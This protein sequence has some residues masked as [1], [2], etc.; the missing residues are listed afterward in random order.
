M[1]P[2]IPAHAA[3]PGER[4]RSIVDVHTILIRD[5]GRILLLERGPGRYGAGLLHLPSGHLE[6]GEPLHLGAARETVEETGVVIDPADLEIAALVHHRQDPSHTRVGAFFACRRWRGEPYNREPDKCTGLVWADPV[7]LP[8]AT[9]D[10]P[11]AGIRAWTAGE[12]YAAHG[13]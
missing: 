3:N 8:Q 10:Y 9:I 4:F 11:A 7:A 13:W 12:G 2:A 6:P 1:A 5:D